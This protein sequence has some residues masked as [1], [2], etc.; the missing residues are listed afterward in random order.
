MTSPM[1]TDT[2]TQPHGFFNIDKPAGLTSHDVVAQ[3]R[4][5]LP[6]KTKVGHTGTLDPF[7]TGVLLI[8]V[9]QATRLSEYTL[10]LSKTYTAAIRLG[11]TSTTDDKMGQ[12]TE[13]QTVAQPTAEEVRTVLSS[14][15]GTIKQ[16]PPAYAAIKIQGK[17]LYEYAR[18][19][20]QVA[21]PARTV[22]ISNI[23]LDSYIFPLLTLTVT[24]GSGTYI[25][26]LGRDI[27]EDLQTGAYVQDLR[28]TAIGDFTEQKAIELE[29]ISR[30][31][32]QRQLLP[33]SELVQHLPAIHIPELN[34]A[35]F[36]SGGSVPV[37]HS[38]LSPKGATKNAI[39]LAVFAQNGKL[40][41]IGQYDEATS[42]LSPQKV[43]T[44]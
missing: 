13:A 21:A 40:L 35:K 43:L 15:V 1:S 17:K 18:E 23:T 19:G 34:V 9:G 27:G 3:I 32:W 44:T 24:C 33:A 36:Q 11:A 31:S 41:G 39:S 10:T 5:C 4:R 6:P 28:R 30:S 14:Y 20:K 2:S 7:A 38:V 16:I 12:I 25:R 42:L 29:E 26:S 37:E 22:R 8:T